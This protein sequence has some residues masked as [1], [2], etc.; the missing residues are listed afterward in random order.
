MQRVKPKL[1]LSITVVIYVVTQNVYRIYFCKNKI[2]IHYSKAF[3]IVVV[4][5]IFQNVYFLKHAQAFNKICDM[6]V[7]QLLSWGEKI[8]Q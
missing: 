6:L 5:P 3:F 4:V 7:S 2:Y 8:C 1:I